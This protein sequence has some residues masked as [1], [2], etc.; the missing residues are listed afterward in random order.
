MA[1]RSPGANRFWKR[2]LVQSGLLDEARAEDAS[3]QPQP[4]QSV[5]DRG[6]A[7]REQTLELTASVLGIAYA[8][9]DREPL[10]LE[11]LRRLEAPRYWCDVGI[12]PLG[13]RTSDPTLAV[14]DPT[15][16]S[17]IDDFLIRNGLAVDR[18]PDLVLALPRDIRRRYREALPGE[19]PSGLERCPRCS[20]DLQP[21]VYG[22]PGDELWNAF[23]RGEVALGGCVVG[24][25]HYRCRA[26]GAT[27]G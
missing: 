8:T 5:V 10:D 15:H 14:A 4:L 6:W 25:Q 11:L 22:L 1:A 17:A 2:V 27:C 20:G 9:L 23:E 18:R 12:L 19:I 7:S 24:D 26:C 16:L 3:G 13:P 21:I